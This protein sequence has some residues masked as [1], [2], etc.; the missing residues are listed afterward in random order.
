MEQQRL[1]ETPAE[2]RAFLSQRVTYF[3]QADGGGPIKIGRSVRG[4]LQKRIIELQVGNAER[5][6][7]RFIAYGDWEPTLHRVFAD[8]RLSGEWFRPHPDLALPIGAVPESPEERSA[9]LRNEYARGFK[10]GYER[11][12][13]DAAAELPEQLTAELK[14]WLDFRAEDA[15]FEDLVSKRRR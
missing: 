14:K 8:L 9:I 11:A 5:L 3:V 15:T 10:D 6:Q 13:A 1:R 12:W 7:T 4:A 2:R